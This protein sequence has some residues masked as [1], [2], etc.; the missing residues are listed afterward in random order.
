MDLITLLE[1]KC[2]YEPMVAQ[3][4]DMRSIIKVAESMAKDLG[5]TP[6]S[7][8]R[9]LIRDNGGTI[10]DITF[11]LFQRFEKEGILDNSIYVRAQRD[12]DIILHAYLSPDQMRYT[13]AHELGHYVLHGKNKSFAC[14]QGDSQI[15]HEAHEFAVGFLIP[16]DSF[17]AEYKK[18]NDINYLTSI[19]R[20]PDNLILRRKLSLGL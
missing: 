13:L 8:L 11:S 2:E 7:D 4:Y 20:V 12:F 3:N 9:E 1:Q 5:I 17:L 16:E 14:Q 18:S 6:N 19:F 15:E 10:H